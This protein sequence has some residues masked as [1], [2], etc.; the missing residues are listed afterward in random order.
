MTSYRGTLTIQMSG[1]ASGY[2]WFSADVPLTLDLWDAS[3]TGGGVLS[4]TLGGSGTITATIVA[5]DGQGSTVSDWLYL[6]S[7]GFSTHLGSLDLPIDSG[8]PEFTITWNENVTFDAQ[9]TTLSAS[10][11][12][13]FS[14]VLEGISIS[15]QINAAGSL[16]ATSS[17]YS[18]A[19]VDA[20][21]GE[22]DGGTTAFAFTVTRLGATSGFGTMPWQV[23]GGGADGAI[24]TD[25][26]GFTMPA[27]T[28]A[29]LPGETTKTL[30]V[31]VLG[32]GLV[33]GDETF[34][35]TLANA[36]GE[37]IAVTSTAQGTILNDDLS[38]LRIEAVDADRAEGGLVG[39]VPGVTNFSFAIVR[40]GGTE[41]EVSVHWAVE[42]DQQ[43]FVFGLLASGTVTFLAGET[44]H[45][46]LVPVAGDAEAEAHDAFQVI[47]SQPQG[48]IL[49]GSWAT[50][51]IINDDGGSAQVADST[52]A[53]ERFELGDGSDLVRFSAGRAA[54]RVGVLDNEV[55]V[56]GPDGRDELVD[57]EWVKFGAEAAITLETLRG[58]P[59]TDELMRFLTTGP[60]GAQ[61]VFALPLPYVGPLALDY[62]YPGTDLD[63]VMAGTSHNE[64]VN[65]AGGN[66]A[67]QMGAGDDVVDGG[68]GNNFLTGGAG[69]DAFFLDGRFAVPVWSCIT[70]W[71][72]GETLTLW[73]WT[74]GVSVGAWAEN[75]G[76]EG[77]K[78]ATFFADIDGSGQVETA[79][80]WA[81]RGV[82]ELP[83]PV[84]ME[85]SGIGVLQFG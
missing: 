5:P 31:E 63:D 54:Y 79:I 37:V 72:V 19:A 69:R 32:D 78:G 49:G 81:G 22:G 60:G 35:V 18:I 12:G 43:D 48:G 45:E 52:A 41:G 38:V 39:D 46:V 14:G 56:E 75:D 47:L 23:T 64:F 33:E 83:A 66:D 34:A 55:R 36:P 8:V 67:A 77:Y 27:G 7:I 4:G 3:L 82:A 11:Q 59:E 26:V 21:R 68:G 28:L 74:P 40:E 61:V 16:A 44:R 13:T 20:A 53:D 29:F 58:E 10:G 80:T 62:V 76:L 9:R 30:T 50:G 65:L 84:A 6:P 2:G 73:G 15:G 85:V 17:A 70:D 25:F 1:Y 51:L 71:E 57:V 24:A 42:G